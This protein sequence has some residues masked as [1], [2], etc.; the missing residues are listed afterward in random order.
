MGAA[1]AALGGMQRF[2]G[3]D[4]NVEFGFDAR[5]EQGRFDYTMVGDTNRLG[6]LDPTYIV[7]RSI[8][9][10]KA[11][12]FATVT[13]TRLT[14]LTLTLGVR[15]NYYDRNTSFL[16]EPRLGLSYAATPNLT[17]KVNAGVFHQDV[18][19][20]VLSSGS[21]N[22]LDQIQAI[23]LGA[24]LEYLPS[25]DVRLTF[26]VYHK[27]YRLLP[28]DPYDPTLSVV[29]QAG[30]NQRFT[31]YQ[32]LSS[33]GRAWTRGIEI[34]IQK[35]MASGG[36]G[37]VSGSVFRCRYEDG[38]GTW[39]DR[40]YDNRYI[41]S[42]VGGYK[43]GG[44]W[45]YGIRWSYAGGAPYTPFDVAA[46][47]RAD[48]GIIDQTRILSVRYPDYHSLNLRIDKK[49]YFDR[50]VLDVYLSVWNAYNRKNVAQYFWNETSNRL[51]T[52]YQWSVLP[53]LGV[54]YEF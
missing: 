17:L 14:D 28:L 35:K 24:G 39:R 34:M 31:T 20:L 38:T 33:S 43:P 53:V 8:A 47:E 12:I 5:Q 11:S 45:E 10:P 18:P 21:F 3:K 4:A 46:S 15:A 52:Q 1:I 2:V 27:E 48:A 36:Y 37:L 19:L 29:D 6:L 40:M 49:F 16:V 7:A 25:P 23:H 13:V 30:F 51:D 44:S 54:E 42:I 41:F 26:E 9:S 50:N 22:G 32:A